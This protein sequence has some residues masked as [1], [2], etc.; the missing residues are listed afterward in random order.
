DLLDYR[1]DIAAD[2]IEVDDEKN[3]ISQ[4]E[5]SIY[6]RPEDV[7]ILNGERNRDNV[8][9]G[10]VVEVTE[11]GSYSRVH[12]ETEANN[13]ILSDVKGFTEVSRGEKV[14]VGFDNSDAIVV[15]A[16]K[17]SV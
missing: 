10:E 2:E 14:D 8:F 17:K 13:R 6:L 4:R 7:K 15:E 1:Q 12:V 11:M 9:S 16:E 5:V 3:G